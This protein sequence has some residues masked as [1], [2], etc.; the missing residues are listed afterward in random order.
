ME[1]L[2]I[3]WGNT[4]IIVGFGFGMVL[5]ILSILVLLLVLWE[6]SPILL[7]QIRKPAKSSEQE[8]TEERLFAT[9]EGDIAAITATM[10]LYFNEIHD[11]ESNVVTIKRIKSSS[12]NSK[13]NGMKNTNWGIKR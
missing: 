6:K 3:N 11:N 1:L 13:I 4:L 9:N 2:I 12:W 7:E 8:I 10:H 5:I